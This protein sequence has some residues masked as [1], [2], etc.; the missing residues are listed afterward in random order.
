MSNMALS[1]T[2]PFALYNFMHGHWDLGSVLCKTVQIGQVACVCINRCIQILL[3][4]ER[5]ILLTFPHSPWVDFVKRRPRTILR[6]IL[7]FTAFY[8][9]IPLT[10]VGI[11]SKAHF[12]GRIYDY[13]TINTTESPNTLTFIFMWINFANNFVIA[14]VLAVACGLIHPLNT[15]EAEKVVIFF[16]RNENAFTMANTTGVRTM[17]ISLVRHIQRYSQ[18]KEKSIIVKQI[19]KHKQAVKKV[20]VCFI[21]N[22]FK[23]F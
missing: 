20:S 8:V 6:L 22:Y 23:G 14:G 13:C 17:P 16:L 10:T 21:Y 3:L 1:M 19:L 7:A 2:M 12:T 11:V 9:S 15:K 18:S 5:Y 4:L